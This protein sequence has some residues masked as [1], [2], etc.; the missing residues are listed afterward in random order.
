MR[1]PNGMGAVIVHNIP[2]NILAAIH[3][4]RAFKHGELWGV[5]MPEMDQYVVYINCDTWPV[6][7]YQGHLKKWFRNNGSSTY[8]LHKDALPKADK[9]SVEELL[10]LADQGPA[11]L[12]GRMLGDAGHV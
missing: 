8:R 6:M 1:T 5:C 11:F 12:I 7:V 10:G 4:R 3:E 2:E 9:M